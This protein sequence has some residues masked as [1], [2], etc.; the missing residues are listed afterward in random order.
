MS[1]Q[2]Q[3]NKKKGLNIMNAE[4]EYLTKCIYFGD[5]SALKEGCMLPE[6]IVSLR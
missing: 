5:N 1:I 3:R 2:M 6:D 4:L